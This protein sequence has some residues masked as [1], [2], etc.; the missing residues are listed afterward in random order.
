MARNVII[1]HGEFVIGLKQ[2]SEPREE[3]FPQMLHHKH[4]FARKSSA[5]CSVIFLISS[6]Q[7]EF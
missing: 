5:D 1:W 7:P 4:T 6:F 3:F 2:T